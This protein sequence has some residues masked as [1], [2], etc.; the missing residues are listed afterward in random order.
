MLIGLIQAGLKQIGRIN[1]QLSRAELKG[2]LSPV[3]KKFKA[4]IKQLGVNTKSGR[5]SV[6]KR[7]FEN[8]GVYKK[9]KKTMD[10]YEKERE[11]EKKEGEKNYQ[12]QKDIEALIMEYI[13]P[14]DFYQ[15][16]RE[17]ERTTN[18]AQSFAD[19]ILTYII[20]FDT[21]DMDYQEEII[22]W[23]KK[24]YSRFKHER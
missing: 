20:E 14:S 12:K 9:L 13:T 16:M 19:R 1:K 5:I 4:D 7:T 8:E 18:S 3:Q 22:E 21:F 17:E 15:E 6:S 24:E 10:E 2:K 11:I 23:L